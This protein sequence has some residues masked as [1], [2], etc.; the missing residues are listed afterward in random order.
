MSGN[1]TPETVDNNVMHATPALRVVLKWMTTKQCRRFTLLTTIALVWTVALA[2]SLM[3]NRAR[4]KRRIIQ[5]LI[6]NLMVIG[7]AI[8]CAYF[9][10][11]PF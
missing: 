9:K 7:I 3:A 4:L 5:I 10:A 8:T 6:W 11:P 2:I 1:D